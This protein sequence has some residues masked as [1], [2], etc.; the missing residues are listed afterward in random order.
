MRDHAVLDKDRAVIT[1]VT[2]VI[3]QDSRHLTGSAR[4]PVFGAGAA[5][6]DSLSYP[7]YR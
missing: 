2:H 3:Q 1:E 6:T 5:D 4:R 7:E